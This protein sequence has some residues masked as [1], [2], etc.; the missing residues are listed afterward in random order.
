M[1]VFLQRQFILLSLVTACLFVLS[2]FVALSD[3]R[4]FVASSTIRQATANVSSLAMLSLLGREIPRLADTV[5]APAGRENEN[6]TGMVFQMVT[7]IHPGDMRSLLGRELPGLLTFDDARLVV[8]GQGTGPADLYVEHPAPP[9]IA[10]PPAAPADQT[11]VDKPAGQIQPKPGTPAAPVANPTTGS[12]KAVFIYH[13]HN[14]ESWI[15]E[16]KMNEQTEAVDHPTRNITL[17]GRRLAQELQDRGIG[18]EVNTDD[19][20]QRLVDRNLSYSLSY[21]ESLKA[22]KAATERNREIRY[23]FDLHRDHKPRAQTTVTLN[24]KN[25]ARVFFVIGM[26]NKN[27]EKNTQFA[28][29]LHELIEKKYPGL[30]RG[31][32]EKNEKTGHGEYN[33]S[34]SPGSLLIE[35]GGTENTLEECYNTAEALADVFAEYYWQAER[36]STSD[37]SN[38]DMR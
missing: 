10:N 5:Q 17:V 1:A 37:P 32:A 27:H 29:S 20:Y 11:P 8:A 19:F 36:V 21:A 18:A 23:F 16:A 34:I 3:H 7:G 6:L 2:S 14:R 26:R 28:K 15:S 30:S 33:Q 12:K 25:Y 9:G 24:G 35:I 31:V 22:I 38:A 4:S 13:T